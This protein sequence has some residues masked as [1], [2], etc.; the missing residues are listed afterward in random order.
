MNTTEKPYFPNI[1][2]N[3]VDE[4]NT[5][6]KGVSELPQLIINR[7]ER[8]IKNYSGFDCTFKKNFY[9]KDDRKIILPLDTRQISEGVEEYI[10][11]T[12]KF[13]F[14]IPTMKKTQSDDSE[15]FTFVF[16]DYAQLKARENS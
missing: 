5:I 8:V 12:D 16:V 7:I 6:H 1:I 4:F 2:T 10:V 13:V 9:R 14:R 3:N 11:L 15:C